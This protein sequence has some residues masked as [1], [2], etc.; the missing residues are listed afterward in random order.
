MFTKNKELLTKNLKESLALLT[1]CSLVTSFIFGLC[2]HERG[3]EQALAE[4]KIESFSCYED[5]TA[6]AYLLE[7]NLYLDVKTVDDYK[8]LYIDNSTSPGNNNF[9]YI[10]Y[11]DM[12][13]KKIK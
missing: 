10:L 8:E 11:P 5:V 1:L 4:A 3:R 7:D 9:G 12:S 13:Y 2:H 6:D